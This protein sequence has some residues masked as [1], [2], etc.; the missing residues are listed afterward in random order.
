MS[1]C[2]VAKVTVGD[3]LV[4]KVTM[5]GRLVDKVTIG[6]CLVTTVAMYECLLAEGTMNG[7]R[8]NIYDIRYY[9]RSRHSRRLWLSN[10]H[11]SLSQPSKIIHHAF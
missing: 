5:S 4:T 1:D 9:G 8:D 10:S 11:S 3:C 7:R 2:L 6:E